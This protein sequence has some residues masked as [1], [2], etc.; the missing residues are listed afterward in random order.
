MRFFK[1]FQRWLLVACVATLAACASG[2]DKPSVTAP[3][4]E[5]VQKP[6]VISQTQGKQLDRL[7]KNLESNLDQTWGVSE[8]IFKPTD[9]VKYSDNYNTRAVINFSNGMIRFETI[10]EDYANALHKEIIYTLLM[11]EAP[12][13]LKLYDDAVPVTGRTPFLA[14]QVVDNNKQPVRTYDQA[15]AFATYLIRDVKVR[16]LENGSYVYYIELPLIQNHLSARASNYISY[17][18]KWGAEYDIE[19]RLIMAIMETESAFNPYAISRSGALGLMQIVPRTAGHDIFQN[20]GYQG[21]PTQE[22]LFDPNLNIQGGSLYLSLLMYKYLDGIQDP[23][24]L[25]YVTIT[26]YN[27]GA[28]GTL[29]IFSRNREEAINI[30]NNMSP[31]EVYNYIVTKHYSLEARNYLIKV[32]RA[33]TKYA[34]VR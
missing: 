29:S 12:K 31:Q 2:P 33:Y 1:N 3:K 27:A 26:S 8:L 9:L 13:D 18:Q 19:P 28:G 7:L 24:S 34:N 25:R 4:K 16:T 22:Y 5:P 21:L 23:T 11:N 17:V 15:Y 20:L 30:I 32:S 6:V 14:N 10:N